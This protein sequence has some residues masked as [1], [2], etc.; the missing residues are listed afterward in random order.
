MQIL[1]FHTDTD[2]SLAYAAQVWSLQGPACSGSAW[3]HA[4]WSLTQLSA[5]RHADIDLKSMWQCAI[6]SVANHRGGSQCFGPGPARPPNPSLLS[7]E[8][9][10]FYRQGP[11]P[12]WT[13]NIS[14]LST[15]PGPAQPQIPHFHRQGPSQPGP[16]PLTS[17]GQAPHFY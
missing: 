5:T 14:H 4:R 10:H 9:P 6:K 1:C 7:T 12:A 11:G 15:G 8:T 16:Q 17:I 2:T 13:P 3:A